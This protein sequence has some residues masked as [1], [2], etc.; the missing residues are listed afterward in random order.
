MLCFLSM[1]AKASYFEA[2]V[3]NK[4][5]IIW[6]DEDQF[7]FG[8]APL[9]QTERDYALMT[10]KKNGDIYRL[11]LLAEKDKNFTFDVLDVVGKKVAIIKLDLKNKRGQWIDSVLGSIQKNES[12]L[13]KKK[14]LVRPSKQE[15]FK[16]RVV[17]EL[18]KQIRLLT[19]KYSNQKCDFM[20]VDQSNLS[21]KLFFKRLVSIN[22]RILESFSE[23]GCD[24][25]E[26]IVT[27]KEGQTAGNEVDPKQLVKNELSCDVQA[28][29]FNNRFLATNVKCIGQL[30]NESK[31]E[32]Q[33]KEKNFY[34]I[35][36]S[37]LKLIVKKADITDSDLVDED[38]SQMI[39]FGL[40]PVGLFIYYADPKIDKINYKK[41]ISFYHL[42]K[43]FE[44]I[45]Q[46]KPYLRN[47]EIK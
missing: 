4:D 6:I 16:V 18:V 41:Q 25:D 27:S 36:D 37:H 44:Q 7:T 33:T 35:Y 43:K 31:S 34:E 40:D 46:S 23:W 9:K 13:D 8:D 2:V 24:L 14:Q 3:K 29:V 17:P 12:T 10:D 39:E 47:F 5:L 19:K 26:K 30:S 28:L 21:D 45:G 20:Y 22:Q 1:S 38:D 15:H 42:K 32:L 11:G